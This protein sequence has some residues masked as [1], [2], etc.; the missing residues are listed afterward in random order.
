MNLKN[1]IKEKAK[2][3]GFYAVGVASSE[4]D[5]VAH[6][7]HLRWLNKGYHAGM[8]FLERNSRQRFD[9]KAHLSNA[10]SVIVCAHNY[11]N[12]PNNNPNDGYIS[13]YARGEDY[14]KVIR[15]KLQTLCDIIVKTQGDFEYKICVDTSAVSE[16]TLAVKAGIGFIGR[17]GIV[18]IPKKKGETE[19]PKGSYHF[20]GVIITDIEIQ[21]DDSGTGTCGKCTKC[22]D[23]CPTDAIVGDGIINTGLCI[24]YH[25]THNKKEIPD[26]LKPKFDNMIFGCDICQNVCPYNNSPIITSENRFH[27]IPGLSDVSINRLSTLS[28]EK[29]KELISNTALSAIGVKSIFRNIKIGLDNMFLKK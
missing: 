11:Y 10:R 15:E 29:L 23:A 7:Y 22:I 1:L 25:T 14:H 18:I 13:I 2:E 5:P 20:L 12:E 3:L 17:N 26:D 27:P 21:L 4:Y 19:P 16:K 8:A 28:N 24:S 9:P 6:D